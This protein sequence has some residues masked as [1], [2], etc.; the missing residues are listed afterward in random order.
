MVGGGEEGYDGNIRG[1]S[2]A[3]ENSDIGG[4]VEAGDDGDIGGGGE[5]GDDGDIGG[6]GEAGDDS[7]I[8]GG[9]EAGEDSDIGGG[10]VAGNDGDIVGGGMFFASRICDYL[11]YCLLECLLFPAFTVTPCSTERWSHRSR[12][13]CAWH[14]THSWTI[15]SWL[16]KLWKCLA[17]QL[18]RKPDLNPFPHAAVMESEVPSHS[19]EL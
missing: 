15:L 17:H 4:G 19:M 3:L 5:A 7:N 18:L 2:E 9:D 11:Y 8:G 6:G 13:V 1:G 16:Q 14:Q 10:G 12:K